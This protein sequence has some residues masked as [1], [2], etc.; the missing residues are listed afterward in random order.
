MTESWIQKEISRTRYHGRRPRKQRVQRPLDAEGEKLQN[1]SD[2]VGEFQ[3]EHT[4]T[5]DKMMQCMV[6]IS[7]AAS[8]S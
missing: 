5:G 6:K 4:T 2:A 8:S 1:P 7:G 3:E